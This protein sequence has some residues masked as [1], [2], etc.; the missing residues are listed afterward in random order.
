MYPE[1]IALHTAPGR[2]VHLQK[3]VELRRVFEVVDVGVGTATFSTEGAAQAFY[4][5]LTESTMAKVKDSATPFPILAAVPGV[6]FY[7]DY[8][9]WHISL[10]SQAEEDRLVHV[11]LHSLFSL[12]SRANPLRVNYSNPERDRRG[13]T[14]WSEGLWSR[15]LKFVFPTV[16]SQGEGTTNL[17]VWGGTEFLPYAEA[18]L[19]HDLGLVE[20]VD[21]EGGLPPGVRSVRLQGGTTMFVRR[22]TPLGTARAADGKWRLWLGDG[23][24]WRSADGPSDALWRVVAPVCFGKPIDELAELLPGERRPAAPAWEVSDTLDSAN[25]LPAPGA[26]ETSARELVI[27]IEMEGETMIVSEDGEVDYDIFE[28]ATNWTIFTAQESPC[29]SS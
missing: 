28:G 6:R 16:P 18:V 3:N 1:R 19:A 15:D 23:E 26:G 2:A 22:S 25:P 29:S 13:I 27:V 4:T 24:G 5:H 10:K 9:H 14:T 11:S 7:Y 20:A 8:G 21:P 12:E 17:N